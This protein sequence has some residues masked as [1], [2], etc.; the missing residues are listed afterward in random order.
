MNKKI[1]K[2]TVEKMKPSEI[3]MAMVNGLKNAHYN[4]HMD[5]FG[6]YKDGI[7]FGCAATNTICE[8]FQKKFTIDNI[9]G[10]KSR[11]DFLEC[12]YVFLCDFEEAIDLLRRGNAKSFL[13]T[14]RNIIYLKKHDVM[15]LISNIESDLKKELQPLTSLNSTDYKKFLH[16]YQ[17]FAKILEKHNY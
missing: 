16:E 6:D 2:K 11:A 9:L 17:T 5:T 1:F 8:I 13:H 7:C 14:L 15:V 3:V 4:V 12:D 10:R